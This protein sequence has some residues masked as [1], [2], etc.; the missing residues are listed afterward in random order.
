MNFK[1]L[2]ITRGRHI[3]KLRPNLVDNQVNM[4]DADELFDNLPKLNPYDVPL[5]INNIKCGY[6]KERDKIR[7][8]LFGMKE[9]FNGKLGSTLPIQHKIETTGTP[10]KMLQYYAS[11]IEREIIEKEIKKLLSLGII[12]CGIV[13]V[14]KPGTSEMRMCI[15]YRP[16]NA[17]T[18]KDQYDLPKI[19]TTLASMVGKRFFSKF[20]LRKRYHQIKMYPA[21]IYKTTFKCHLGTFVYTGMAFGQTNS[22]NLK[23]TI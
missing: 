20:D 12:D 15:D 16:L 3:Y 18:V 19:D 6:E 22:G 1:T 2:E 11:R 4:V 17:F 21:H 7:R 13:L 9:V 14:A 8:L 5:E 10:T 23:G